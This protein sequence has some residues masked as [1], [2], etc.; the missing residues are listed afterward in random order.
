[1]KFI[2]VY[3]DDDDLT[4]GEKNRRNDH[5]NIISEKV[6]LHVNYNEVQYE[7]PICHMQS[8]I[9]EYNGNMFKAECP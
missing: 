3:V 4:E 5:A 2:D 9:N 6:K 1:M 7:C 8:K